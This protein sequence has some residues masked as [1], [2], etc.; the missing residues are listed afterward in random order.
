MSSS[1]L[2]DVHDVLNRANAKSR[3]M[4]SAFEAVEK[5]KK[6]KH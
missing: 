3:S 6:E 1:K 2:K 4:L 5:R